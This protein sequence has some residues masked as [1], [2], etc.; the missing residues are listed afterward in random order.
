MQWFMDFTSPENAKKNGSITNLRLNG[1]QEKITIEH[2]LVIAKS[3]SNG[4]EVF[5]GQYSLVNGVPLA[6]E[7]DIRNK[8]EDRILLK[9][10]DPEVNTAMDNIAF[11]PRLDG[12]RLL[13]LSALELL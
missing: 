7:I 6:H 8:A 1:Q 5:Y 9:L 12:L 4:D 10:Q 2:G 13:P 3:T 11:K